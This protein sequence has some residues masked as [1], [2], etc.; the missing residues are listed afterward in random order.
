M[1]AKISDHG[2]MPN[3]MANKWRNDESQDHYSI[4]FSRSLEYVWL[5]LHL[6]DHRTASIRLVLQ[7]WL[8]LLLLDHVLGWHSLLT[9]SS[10]GLP[11]SH[12]GIFLYHGRE[13]GTN[14]STRTNL[15]TFQCKLQVLFS[16]MNAI[17]IHAMAGCIPVDPIIRC[18]WAC[19]HV[20]LP[21][22]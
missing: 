4:P 9:N 17:W 13:L 22:T 18:L 1:V 12:Q 19:W 11:L 10:W 7:F 21:L 20:E 15:M 8:A 14:Q 3:R 5:S 2:Q 6:D 16:R